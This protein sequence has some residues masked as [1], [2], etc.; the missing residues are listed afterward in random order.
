M[1]GCG[2][3]GGEQG[4]NMGRVV[5]VLAGMRQVPGCTITLRARVAMPR[6]GWIAVRCWGRDADGALINRD[7]ARAWLPE[8]L[9]PG[10]RTVELRDW[11][12]PHLYQRGEDKPILP[13]KSSVPDKFDVFL[14]HTHADSARV[15]WQALAAELRPD[16]GLVARYTTTREGPRVLRVTFEGS[17]R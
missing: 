7:F 16:P 6:S 3:P 2:L 4:F 10:A 1:L 8:T 9:G 14:S 12:L 13:D 5:A 15:D 11:S 17:E